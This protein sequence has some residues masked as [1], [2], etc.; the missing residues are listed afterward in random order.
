MGSRRG[1]RTSRHAGVP[2]PSRAG[3]L[4]RARQCVFIQS[5]KGL[6][7][8]GAKIPEAPGESRR[9]GVAGSA[10]SGRERKRGAR[11]IPAPHRTPV[12]RYPNARRPCRRKARFGPET[13]GVCAPRKHS[14]SKL[15]RIA[16]RPG[17]RRCALC[18]RSRS[19]AEARAQLR[20]PLRLSRGHSGLVH[21]RPCEPA[22][23]RSAGLRAHRASR[24]ARLSLRRYAGLWGDDAP[25]YTVEVRGATFVRLR[26]DSSR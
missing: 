8:S 22:G 26:E 7:G 11:S 21:Q 20:R 1:L 14:E 4:A 18:V 3:P 25:S 19:R 6:T 10:G 2:P 23:Q 15:G 16:A 24:C 9:T 12:R 13:P 5:G 17:R